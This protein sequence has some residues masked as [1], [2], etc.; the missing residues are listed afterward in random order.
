[1]F[2][3]VTMS[4]VEEVEKAMKKFNGYVSFPVYIFVV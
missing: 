2:G 1:M 3:C 4:T